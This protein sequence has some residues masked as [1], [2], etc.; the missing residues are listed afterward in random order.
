MTCDTYTEN[1]RRQREA[2]ERAGFTADLRALAAWLD[3]HPDAPLPG[4]MTALVPVTPGAGQGE[5]EA[6]VDAFAVRHHVASGAD[7]GCYGARVT[8]G[9]VSY[10]RYCT[11]EECR[12]ESAAIGSY[13]DNLRLSVSAA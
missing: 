7:N 10:L 5:R 9:R 13:E 3:E 4:P 2:R 8:F 1:A 12:A 6:A 11:T